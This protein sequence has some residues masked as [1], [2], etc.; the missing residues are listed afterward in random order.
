MGARSLPALLGSTA[1]GDTTGLW[2][3]M[4]WDWVRSRT[5]LGMSASSIDME[6]IIDKLGRVTRGIFTEET[7]IQLTRYTMEILQMF[8]EENGYFEMPSLFVSVV[9]PPANEVS[10]R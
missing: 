5:N 9:F 10:R 4:D 8:N 6:R 2:S 1:S 7:T 3:S